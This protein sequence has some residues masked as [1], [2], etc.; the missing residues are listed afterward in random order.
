MTI[1]ARE[2]A[3]KPYL[4]LF[5]LS[6]FSLPSSD[7]SAPGV[8]TNNYPF[9]AGGRTRKPHRNNGNNTEWYEKAGLHC[10]TNHRPVSS[11]CSSS[12][13][14]PPLSFY[15]PFLYSP[16]IYSH[17]PSVSLCSFP[18]DA[19][20]GRVS[21]VDFRLNFS[22]CFLP[23]RFFLSSPHPER[24]VH[25]RWMNRWFRSRETTTVPFDGALPLFVRARRPPRTHF[26]PYAHRQLVSDVG[27]FIRRYHYSRWLFEKFR[28]NSERKSSRELSDIFC[29]SHRKRWLNEIQ[30]SSK[31]RKISR[32]FIYLKKKTDFLFKILFTATCK[33][34]K[35]LS[36]FFFFY[37][38]L[39]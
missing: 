29:V 28:K 26:P 7:F 5:S 31:E 39:F 9:S 22:F 18:L 30:R 16:S 6:Q 19:S 3:D 4:S 12:R 35:N 1:G 37:K 15:D 17:H 33:C 34:I 23:P 20:C 25:V 36:Y 21:R 8:M 38:F 10:R 14:P 13:F 2:E 11:F 27:Y 24:I 32:Y